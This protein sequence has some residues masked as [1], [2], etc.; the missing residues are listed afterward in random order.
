MST[1]TELDANGGLKMW[2][3]AE[4]AKPI[5]PRRGPWGRWRWHPENI[6]L[7]LH[8]GEGERWLYEVDLEAFTSS[9]PT[10]DKIIQFAEKGWAT[11]ED[12]GH[13]VR[14]IDDMLRPQ[15]RLCGC[16]QDKK[17]EPA[18]LKAFLLR[19]GF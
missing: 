1:D 9:A 19:E 4:L 11:A 17:I 14:A 13:L 3:A 2:D 10:L 8:E 16:G 12:V 5:K 7:R 15:E 6:T 18:R